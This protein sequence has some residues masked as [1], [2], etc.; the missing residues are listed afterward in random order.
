MTLINKYTIFPEK[1]YKTFPE[2]IYCVRLSKT[3][4]TLIG[5][6]LAL[7][8]ITKII[9]KQTDKTNQNQQTRLEK[10]KIIYNKN[11]WH[12]RYQNALEKSCFT[13]G[14]YIRTWH[15]LIMAGL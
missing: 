1:K 11:I 2:W 7:A 9:Y 4:V 6:S 15:G 3:W 10:C 5:L 13:S 12:N 8:N 14:K